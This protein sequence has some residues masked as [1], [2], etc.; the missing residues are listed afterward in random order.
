M[1]AAERIEY[2]R[3]IADLRAG[4]DEKDFSAF[5][6]EGRVMTIDQAIDFAVTQEEMDQ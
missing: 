4:M 2:D 6:S 1:T 5:W 3:E